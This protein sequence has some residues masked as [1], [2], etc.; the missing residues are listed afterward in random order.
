MSGCDTRRLTTA[1][2]LLS[3]VSTRTADRD[4]LRGGRLGPLGEELCH[5]PVR[6]GDALDL[7]G[8]GVDD[9][10]D[11]LQAL[12]DLIVR[13]ASHLQL[14]SFGDVLRDQPHRGDE[15]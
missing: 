12:H 8:R 6:L 15:D 5:E 10:L 7:Y 4:I 14:A 11:P 13:H 1:T 3:T 2:S 9:L